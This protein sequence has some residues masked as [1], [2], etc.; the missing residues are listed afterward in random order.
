[1][2]ATA[3]A[4]VQPDA[5]RFCEAGLLQQV[6]DGYCCDQVLQGF[7]VNG[8]MPIFDP[9]GQMFFDLLEPLPDIVRETFRSL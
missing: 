8:G 2:R 5:P 1:M 3:H 7:V 9:A 4:T 6:R